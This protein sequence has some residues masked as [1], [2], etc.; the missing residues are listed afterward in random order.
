MPRE[1]SQDARVLRTKAQLRAA[2]LALCEERDIS[3]IS[4][5]D[6]TGRAG[7]NRNT[8]YR[9]FRNKDELVADA[10]DSAFDSL[11]APNRQFVAAH[12]RLKAS[13]VPPPTI[14]L[15]RELERSPRLY[16]R[17][18]GDVGSPEF[19]S[20]LRTFYEGQFLRLWNDLE[21]EAEPGSPPVDLRAAFA[22]SSMESTIRWWLTKGEAVSA[23]QVAS[24]VWQLLN[25]LWFKWQA[26]PSESRDAPD[27][28]ADVP[29][30]G[31]TRAH[32]EE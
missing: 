25:E 31:Q 20:R 1:R 8:F 4:V 3:E 18:L 2:V 32:V 30:M 16:L 13:V 11:T 12:E 29:L 19:A 26:G 21:M 23:D 27:D 22:A 10:L 24:W 28:G 15:F 9:H 7:I 6:V 5:K 14:E 17:L